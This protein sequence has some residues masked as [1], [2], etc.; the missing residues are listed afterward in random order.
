LWVE[1]DE[2]RQGI[3]AALVDRAAEFAFGSGAA[4]VYLL[5]RERRRAYYESLGWS[6]H[7]ADA[8]EPGLHVLIRN[9]GK[10]TSR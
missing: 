10:E 5:S 4:R 7:E 2:R 6:V 8:P 1:T 9:A 3:G